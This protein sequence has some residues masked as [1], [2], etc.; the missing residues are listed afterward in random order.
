MAGRSAIVPFKILKA[1]FTVFWMVPSLGCLPAS[2]IVLSCSKASVLSSLLRVESVSIAVW[3][4]R[5]ITIKIC[6]MLRPPVRP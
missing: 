4:V 2:M 3:L 5:P 6:D 1:V